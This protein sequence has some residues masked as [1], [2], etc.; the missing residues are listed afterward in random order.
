MINIS[1]DDA[2]L[3]EQNGFSKEQVGATINHYREQGLNDDEIQGRINNKI[4]E[5]KGALNPVQ[6]TQ[7]QPKGIDLTPSGIINNVSGA[8][9]DTIATPVEMIKSGETNPKKAYSAVANRRKEFE[10]EYKKQAPIL[11]GAKDLGAD[12]VGYSMLPIAKGGNLLANFAKN[13][14]VQGGVPMALESV[15]RGGNALGG[16]AGGSL[17][18]AGVQALPYVG[19]VAGV[20]P[21]VGKLVSRTVGRVKPETIERAVK[22]DSKALDLTEKEAQNL[23][24]DTTEA[25]RKNYKDL[26]QKRG[27]T[28]GNLLNELPEDKTFTA[29]QLLNNYDSI[30]NNYSLS[31]NEALNPARNATQKELAKIED[32]LY[33]KADENLQ[34]LKDTIN[35]AKY[36]KG[37]LEVLHHSYG[38]NKWSTA[39]NSIDNS[40][41][42][43]NRWFNDEI[44]G[45]L[46]K[47]PEWVNDPEKITMLENQIYQKAHVPEDYLQEMYNKFYNIV[48]GGQ[49][50]KEASAIL[51]K[52]LYDINKNISNM[53][54]WDKPGAALKNDV[55]EQIYLSNANKISDLSP[56]LAQANKAYSD[57]MDFQKNE[58]V[59]RILNNQNNIDTASSALRN[60]NSTV[61]KGNTNR[62]IQDLENIL[63]NNGY[64]PFLNNIDDVNAAMDLLNIRGTGDSWLANLATQATRPALKAVRAYNQSNIPIY[65]DNIKQAVSPL[66]QR[67]LAPLA[68]KGAAPLLYG[69]VQYNEQ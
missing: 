30:L 32:L 60:Y 58:G 24:M 62:N 67:L 29:E 52:E 55:L 15:K 13:A 61:T 66:A 8:V 6:Q 22:A 42:E 21:G 35:E 17:L 36:P 27:E 39:I 19:R 11:S 59:R 68:V 50:D 53:V 10:K 65:I 43:A 63:V 40:I 7:E 38:K 5:F 12:L 54:D 26:L 44:L 3:F 9:A 28:V 45:T 57:L 16:L 37:K 56:E 23:L 1:E 14:V 48:G 49:L 4:G 46:K 25:V 64:E 33:S 31:K 41:T 69:G 47:H 18:G 2:M 34:G 51:P 20:V